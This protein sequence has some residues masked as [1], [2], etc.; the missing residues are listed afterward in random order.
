[1]FI[2]GATSILDSRVKIIWGLIINKT[3]IYPM[4]AGNVFTDTG[5]DLLLAIWLYLKF[6]LMN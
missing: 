3:I 5:T 1:M 6:Y 4:A 2:Q